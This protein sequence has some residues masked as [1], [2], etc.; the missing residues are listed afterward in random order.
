M[1][2]HIH[3]ASPFLTDE[4]LFFAA[5]GKWLLMKLLLVD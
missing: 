3:I 5:T 1:Y 2:T 4:T